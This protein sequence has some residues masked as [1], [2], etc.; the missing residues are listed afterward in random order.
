MYSS[1]SRFLVR[2]PRATFNSLENEPFETRIRNPQ[3]QEAIYIASSVL[4]TELQKY[5]AGE[6][7]DKEEIRRIELSLCRYLNRMSTRCTPFGLFAGCSVGKI[8]GDKTNIIL[9]RTIKRHTR[10][11]MYYLCALSQELSKIPEIKTQLKYFPNTTIYPAGN[12]LR[13]VECD[14]LKHGRKHKITSVEQSS[15][16]K[17]ILKMSKNSVKIPKI[18]D[19]LIRQGIPQRDAMGYIGEIIDSQIIISE[20]SPLIT[21][22]DFLDKIISILELLPI[23]NDIFEKLKE[24]KSQLNCINKNVNCEIA[25]YEAVK[26]KIKKINLPFEEKYI[27]QSDMT[28]NANEAIL[29]ND[30]MKEV[31]SALSF[32]SRITPEEKN[33]NLIKFTQAFNERYEN[34]E[35]PLMEVLDPEMGIGYPANQLSNVPAPLV[36]DMVLPYQTSNSTPSMQI[37]DYQ[38]LLHQK[39]VEALVQNRFEIEFTDEDVK[40]MKEKWDNLPFTMSCLFKVLKY[41]ENKTELLLNSFFGS[42]GANLFAR[43]SHTDD[44]IKQFVREIAHK[45]QDL[46]PNVLFAEIVHV[47]SSR[48]GNVL[49]R[50]HIR[51]YEILYLAN[52]DLSENRIIRMTDLTISIKGGE[53]ILKSKKLNKEIIPRLTNALNYRYTQMPVYRFLCDIQI[54]NGRGGL[55]F[56]WGSIDDLFTFHPRVKYKNIILSPASWTVKISDIKHLFL[57]SEAELIEEVAKFRKIHSI[58]RLALLHD[59]DNELF[60]DFEKLQNIQAL[61]SIIKEKN[62]IRLSEFLFDID[63]AMVRDENGNP[64]LNECIVVFYRDEVK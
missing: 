30:I 14:Y 48:A 52:S 32:L 15:I 40:D 21:G 31:K 18:L 46:N 28:R 39:T 61:F 59:G 41:N 50:P 24:I 23:K 60:V 44:E 4:Y 42:C 5:L 29:G 27:F 8:S 49:S 57:K 55:F 17:W 62:V 63:N 47:P 45:E 11:D 9:E 6:I 34:R 43:F 25:F 3:I 12:R 51:D 7:I 54:K 20:L 53:V 1:F 35:M 56:N 33:E 10:L 64:Y 58:P 13:Y 2:T 19:Y 36:D 38:N 37:M 22:E 26:E 16:L